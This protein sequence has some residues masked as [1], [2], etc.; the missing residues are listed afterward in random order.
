MQADGLVGAVEGKSGDGY[1]E[2]LPAFVFHLVAA[3]HDAGRCGEGGAAGVIIFVAGFKG[4]LLA[5]DPCPAHFVGF[6]ARVGDAPVAAEE[7]DGFG[8]HIFDRDLV[9]P[10]EMAVLGR[11]FIVEISRFNGD[12][13]LPGGGGVGVILFLIIAERA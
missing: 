5:D 4:R 13:D 10:D 11:R 6:A 3:L 1:V 9:G 7:L 12:A 8:A 2:A